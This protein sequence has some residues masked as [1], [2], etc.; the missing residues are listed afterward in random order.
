[1]FNKIQKFL[2]VS[3]I[4]LGGMV[5]ANDDDDGSGSRTRI[6]SFGG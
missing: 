4:L 6:R 2:A 1:M 5:A 3:M